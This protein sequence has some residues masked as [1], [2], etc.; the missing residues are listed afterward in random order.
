VFS[1]DLANA[2]RALA[3]GGKAAS[4]RSAVRDGADPRLD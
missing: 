4:W 2:E 1:E 3:A